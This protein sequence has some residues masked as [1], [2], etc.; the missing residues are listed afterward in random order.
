MPLN[1]LMLMVDDL[2][3]E[4]GA[5]GSDW[6]RTPH[7][8]QLAE[9]SVLF[10]EAFAAVANCA[11]SRASILTGL[12]PRTHGVLDLK[13]HIRDVLPN[14]ITLPQHFRNAGYLAV[15]YGK[16]NHQFLDDALSWS[17][18]SEFP[19]HHDYRGKR[20]RAWQRAGGFIRGFKYNQYHEAD[21]VRKQEY[22]RSL[23]KQ[24]SKMSPNRLLPPM[25]RGTRVAASAYTDHLIASSAIAALRVLLKQRRPWFLAVGF[26]RPHLPFNAPEEFFTRVRRSSIPQPAPLRPPPSLSKLTARHLRCG[27]GELFDY[28]ISRRGFLATSRKGRHLAH[29]YAACVSFV[30]MQAR[31][32]TRAPSLARPRTPR[33][34]ATGGAC[35]RC[36]AQRVESQSGGLLG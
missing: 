10:T 34:I 3:P 6:L 4:L 27:D 24:G 9:R 13:T 28:N 2:R 31:F 16:I 7:I 36:G 12:R 11:P 30:D 23:R 15:S 33:T 29:A 22:F 20:G 21:N 1:V 8:D 5:Y 14:V 19:D 17:P 18:Q 35:A 26:I 32:N 25:E